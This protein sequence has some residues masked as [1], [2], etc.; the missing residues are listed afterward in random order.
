MSVKRITFQKKQDMSDNNDTSRDSDRIFGDNAYS[1]ADDDDDLSDLFGVSDDEEEEEEDN[2]EE[3]DSF[4]YKTE[5]EDDEN[6][7]DD[8]VKIHPDD[9]Q[10]DPVRGYV[11]SD[12]TCIPTD[13]YEKFLDYTCACMDKFHGM[14][15]FFGESIVV[16]RGAKSKIE[17]TFDDE[18]KK[19]C[20]SIILH[21]AVEKDCDDDDLKIDMENEK[22]RS[23]MDAFM[24][25]NGGCRVSLFRICSYSTI[26]QHKKELFRQE[27]Q[28]KFDSLDKHDNLIQIDFCVTYDSYI[29]TTSLSSTKKS[30]TNAKKAKPEAKKKTKDTANAEN[31][32]DN[33]A[34][35]KSK[36]AAKK[37]NDN[38]KKD[39][40]NPAR[41][42][43]K[44][45][46]K[47]PASEKK[48][49]AAKPKESA[50]TKE[51]TKSEPPKKKK[52]KS[53][54]SYN[55]SFID[56][57]PLKHNDAGGSNVKNV[58]S[59]EFSTQLKN[60]IDSKL[61]DAVNRL[62]V[63]ETLEFP[64][65][66][67]MDAKKCFAM[68]HNLAVKLQK[69]MIDKFP[70]QRDTYLTVMHPDILSF[71]MLM[72]ASSAQKSSMDSKLVDT[73]EHAK[74][75]SV[76]SIDRNKYIDGC[77]G[78]AI[79]HEKAYNRIAFGKRTDET[80]YVV[81]TNPTMAT[82]MT[83]LWIV[84]H[85]DT[86]LEDVWACSIAMFLCEKKIDPSTLSARELWTQFIKEQVFEKTVDELK[87]S[88][89][90]SWIIYK[91]GS[92]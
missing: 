52:S 12:G 79:Q 46:A 22:L 78:A 28:A 19:V 56:L 68:T 20:S 58:V 4:H 61:V 6:E 91:S 9:Y 67:S 87:S 5:N 59:D 63:K 23:F 92:K 40:S 90:S 2:E 83:L 30:N 25:S 14:A 54:G 71:D 26:E 45:S 66:G 62:P 77:T 86:Y 80:M 33:R 65:K 43:E 10:F 13:H 1:D 89:K 39:K 29:K 15:A 72:T 73:V 3:E 70:N 18:F 53:S 57:Q 48:K 37:D 49:S 50:K 84:S 31:K 64:K 7:D 8:P 16:L 24:S 35:D 27:D 47:P 85:Y 34:K 76:S 11:F 75:G 41:K 36:P 81:Y 42:K 88:L 21:I 82:V 51:K 69:I 38:D 17:L 74:D 55:V 32:S 44:Q 60:A